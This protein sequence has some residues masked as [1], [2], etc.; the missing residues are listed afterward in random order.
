[1]THLSDAASM[2][3][4][5]VTARSLSSRLTSWTSVSGSSSTMAGSDL[6]LVSLTATLNFIMFFFR[7]SVFR[8]FFELIF[9]GEGGSTA[10]EPRGS[11]LY[12]QG[13]RFRCSTGQ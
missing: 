1:M 9:G 6:N 11:V 4:C 8:L 5:E 12:L 2:S 13:V 10:G 3:R 7:L